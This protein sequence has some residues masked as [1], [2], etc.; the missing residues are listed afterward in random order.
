MNAQRSRRKFTKEFKDDAVSLVVEQG[1]SCAEVSRRL[2]ISE[3]NVNRWVRQ[4]Q[5][6]SESASTD[7]LTREQLESELKRLRK[8]NKRLEMEREIL[9]KAAA[10]FA[11][12]SK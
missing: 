10:F 5:D 3:N 2:G 4:Y 8:E 1:Y 9:K 12:E 11:N 7:G 6:R